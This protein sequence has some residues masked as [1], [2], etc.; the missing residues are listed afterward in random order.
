M[1]NNLYKTGFM[2][3]LIAVLFGACVKK[4]DLL[5]T[6]DITSDVVYSTADGYKKAFAKVYGSFALGGN[7]GANGGG[8]IQGIDG[9]FSDFLR[10]YWNAQELSTDEAVV[11][12]GDAGLPDFHKMNWSA[13]NQFIKALYYRSFYQI[14]VA[15]DFIRQAS[16]ANLAARGIA[17]ADVDNI[18]KYRAEARFLRAYQYAVLM[19]L[20]GNPAFITDSVAIGT[21][22]PTQ[23]Q[24]TQLFNF[25]E[26]EL[27]EIEPLLAAPK[28][29]E[30]GRADQAAAWSLLARIYLNAE[31]YTGTPKYTEAITYSAK[32]IGAGYSLLSD[33]TKIMRAD[34]HLNNPEFIFTINY[35]GKNTTNWGGT[36]YLTHAAVGGNMSA[37]DFGIGGGW[38]GLRTTKNLVN[39]FD[40]DL[41]M[42]ALTATLGAETIY[43]LVGSAVNDWGQ[44]PDIKFYQTATAGIYEAYVK[45]KKGEWKVRTNNS[46][47]VNYGDSDKNGVLDQNNDNNIATEAGYYKVVL[48]S[49]TLAYTVT[50]ITDAR[51]QFYTNTNGVEIKDIGDF[52]DGYA[53][54]KFKNIKSDGSMGSDA[55][56]VDID[57][58]IFRLA[59][60]YLTYAEAVKRGGSGGSLTNAVDYLNKLRERA[61]KNK[62]GNITA[63]D[64]DYILNERARE[65][66]WEG[67][68]RTDLIRFGD[69][70]TSASYLWPWKGDVIG[71]KGVESYRKLYPIPTDDLTANPNLKQNTGY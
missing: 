43:G 3:S 53:I 20:F 45:F 4:L 13:N 7:N 17:A 64:L 27:K 16:D 19:D 24:R 22:L 44:T 25:V 18:K 46:W 50:P 65:L 70:F 9:G 5:P 55:T 29:N 14:T 34:N 51:A 28:T 32:V 71:G 26:K 49:A 62:S 15:N 42:S 37:A 47:D 36:T 31:V 39:A 52:K 23:I 2:L 67:F 38:G 58:P 41:N 6:N 63:Y 12:W 8:D 68:R 59:E 21:A 1:K 69:K 10:L 48:N 11:S 33:Y 54:T 57:M 60:M 61:L 66:Y 56:Q 30:Y 40:Y 35:D